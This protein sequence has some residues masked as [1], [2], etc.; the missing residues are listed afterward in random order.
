MA[1]DDDAGGEQVAVSLG[2]GQEPAAVTVT[3]GKVGRDSRVSGVD[4]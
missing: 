3:H 2:V 1:P 4:G